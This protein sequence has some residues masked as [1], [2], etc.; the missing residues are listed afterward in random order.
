MLAKAASEEL[1]LGQIDL[2]EIVEGSSRDAAVGCFILA[3]LIEG[4]LC[5]CRDAGADDAVSLSTFDVYDEHGEFAWTCQAR[6]LFRRG[7][8]SRCRPSAVFLADDA[9]I[10][11]R[12]TRSSPREEYVLKHMVRQAGPKSSLV[13]SIAAADETFVRFI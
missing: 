5:G 11:S 1:R 8:D 7:R 13:F 2:R 3:L 6:R 9:A 4:L 12:R 10:R